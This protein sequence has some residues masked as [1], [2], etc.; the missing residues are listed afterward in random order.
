MHVCQIPNIKLTHEGVSSG[1][2]IPKNNNETNLP[3]SNGFASPVSTFDKLKSEVYP[4]SVEY[5]D[6]NIPANITAQIP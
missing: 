5:G 3:K 6:D 1:S 2:P 4:L